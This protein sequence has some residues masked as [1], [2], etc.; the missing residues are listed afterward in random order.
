MIGATVRIEDR[1]K[2]I[3]KAVDAAAFKNLSIMSALTRSDAML[4]ILERD[5][6]SAPGTPP[7]THT[8]GV[9]KRGNKRGRKK[10]DKKAGV[11]PRSIVYRV[12][13]RELSSVVGPSF[14]VA[15]TVGMAHEFGGLY[16]GQIFPE[17]PFMKP[18]L[19]HH[20]ENF[21]TSFKSSIGA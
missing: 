10:G 8:H 13:K 15:G 19:E 21:A 16:K 2:D 14:R 1:T 17:R 6:P 9:Y 3:E 4:S 5:G 20:L 7:H 18:A 11:L 12:D